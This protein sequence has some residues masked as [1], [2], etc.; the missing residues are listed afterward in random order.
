MLT[1]LIQIDLLDLHL[2]VEFDNQIQIDLLDFHLDVEF[3][4]KK[5]LCE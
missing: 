3:D 4:N 1:F 2:D 5:L